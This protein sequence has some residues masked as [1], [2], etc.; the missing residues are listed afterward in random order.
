MAEIEVRHVDPVWSIR[1]LYSRANPGHIS[2]LRY[3]IALEQ[4]RVDTPN[5]PQ[6]STSGRRRP[7]HNPRLARAAQRMARD[8]DRPLIDPATT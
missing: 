4:Q 2:L 7:G 8:D 3:L 1:N 5:R 6:A